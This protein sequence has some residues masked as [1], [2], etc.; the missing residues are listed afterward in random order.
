VS[1]L[2]HGGRSLH[3][4]SGP[5]S[6]SLMS[7]LVGLDPYQASKS[8]KAGADGEKLEH[9]TTKKHH[10]FRDLRMFHCSPRKY[11][12]YIPTKKWPWHSNP[13][14]PQPGIY[15]G[16]YNHD[17]SI[18]N[19]SKSS[20]HSIRINPAKP[21]MDIDGLWSASFWAPKTFRASVHGQSTLLTSGI[22]P[23]F[24]KFLGGVLTGGS[25]SIWNCFNPW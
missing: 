16:L 10:T 15:D 22:S 23:I 17:H 3:D 5:K 2:S 6:I 11:S 19:S 8:S 4:P 14:W 13:G 21:M 18:N 24:T 20:F 12:I 7:A 25:D 9:R 1:I